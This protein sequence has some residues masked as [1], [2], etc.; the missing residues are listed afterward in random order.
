MGNMEPIEYLKKVHAIGKSEDSKIEVIFQMEQN[1]AEFDRIFFRK[2][3]NLTEDSLLL[4]SVKNQLF[5][6]INI[7]TC[8]MTPFLLTSKRRYDAVEFYDEK[9]FCINRET[10]SIDVFF[11][12]KKQRLFNK[13]TLSFAKKGWE[14]KENFQFMIWKHAT[15]GIIYRCLLGP[16]RDGRYMNFDIREKYFESRAETE[17]IIDKVFLLNLTMED[18]NDTPPDIIGVMSENNKSILC[19]HEDEQYFFEYNEFQEEPSKK[20]QVMYKDRILPGSLKQMHVYYPYDYFSQKEKNMLKSD[21]RNR[22]LQTDLG[23]YVRN[24][25]KEFLLCIDGKRL[26]KMYLLKEDGLQKNGVLWTMKGMDTGDNLSPTDLSVDEDT[27]NIFI[28]F[29]DKI[30]GLK[31]SGREA[32]VF[33]DTQQNHSS[34]LTKEQEHKRKEELLGDGWSS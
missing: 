14:L 25:Y 12:S 27:G 6:E 34:G 20:L 33:S 17:Q 2:G 21:A 19:Y 11:D 29:P 5:T 26:H 16:L 13:R 22:Q 18:E 7:E 15:A 9:L 4:F 1:L 8:I 31:N 30:K 28:L 3:T 24:K 23:T 32:A 10:L